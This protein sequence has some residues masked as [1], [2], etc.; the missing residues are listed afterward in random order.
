MVADILLIL[1]A[2]THCAIPAG[3]SYEAID[4]ADRYG[5]DPVVMLGYLCSEHGADWTDDPEACS[6]AGACGP[7][8]LMPRWRRVFP[9]TD[10]EVTA[11]LLVYSEERHHTKCRD[12]RHDWRAHLKAGR[13]GRNLDH[14]RWS[15]QRWSGYEQQLDNDRER[16]R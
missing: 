8:Q 12:T 5:A 7:Y 14:I 4:A 2:W 11:Q 9:G 10:A 13:A 6:H 1:A 16:H 3:V 15:V